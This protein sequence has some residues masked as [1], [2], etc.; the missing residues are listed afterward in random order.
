MSVK[1][2]I[3]VI[4]ILS[5]AVCGGM[6]GVNRYFSG[7]V[8]RFQKTAF[9]IQEADKSLSETRLAEKTYQIYGRLEDW[10]QAQDLLT[11]TR[12]R[13]EKA[14]ALLATDYGEEDRAV[15]PEKLQS[16]LAVYQ[17]ELENLR[18][19][20]SGIK[21]GL[22]DFAQTLNRIRV[23]AKQEVI[24]PVRKQLVQARIHGTPVRGSVHAALQKSL[25]FLEKLEYL[26]I[27]LNHLFLFHDKSAYQ[28]KQTLLKHLFRSVRNLRAIFK[29]NGSARF[30]AAGKQI[31]ELMETA[32]T[33]E[34][35]LILLYDRQAMLAQRFETLNTELDQ[36]SRALMQSI[37]KQ[38]ESRLRMNTVWE[39]AIAGIG[40][41]LLAGFAYLLARSIVT[42]LDEV[43]HAVKAMARGDYSQP[44]RYQ[45]RNELGTMAEAFRE[46]ARAQAHKARVARQ[47]ADGD[48]QV[49]VDV[50]SNQDMLGQALQ[51]MGENLNRLIGQVQRMVEEV[52]TGAKQI[53]DSSQSLSQGA[54]QQAASL[55]EI[56]STL[57]QINAQTQSNAENAGQASQL[58]DQT[59]EAADQGQTEMKNMMAAMKEISTAS[60]SIAKINKVIDEIAFQTNLLAL[61]ASVEAARAGRHGHGFAVVANEVRNLAARSAKAAKETSELLENASQKVR[62]GNQMA[63]ETAQALNRIVESSVQM[64]DRVT[65]IAAASQEQAEGIRQINQ[66]VGQID[67]VT[68]QNTANAEQTAAAGQELSHR[69]DAL[70]STLTQFQIDRCLLPVQPASSQGLSEEKAPAAPT[71]SQEKGRPGPKTDKA[72]QSRQ[73][74]NASERFH[75]PA[76]RSQEIIALDDD[77]FGRY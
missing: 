26:R 64:A 15:S 18:E 6:I 53:S 23:L 37:Q 68:Q 66:G 49:S 31:H 50:A 4:V 2:K 28:E 52:A 22:R 25:I 42:P 65:E 3:A 74:G 35:R 36:G 9:I 47:I 61:N 1:K 57:N 41:L 73:A 27:N 71:R 46:M 12:T 48:L 7:Q 29:V 40:F 55:E 20:V 58:A 63:E 16:I 34:S 45:G 11:Q 32:R 17:T 24:G 38:T 67:R 43:V 62:N 70:R 60:R 44:I 69:A 56:S 5:I 51:I 33:L 8:Q 10:Q 75:P 59:R 30:M 19:G 54:T 39:W 77:D 72:D 13:L 21:S 76:E 14:K